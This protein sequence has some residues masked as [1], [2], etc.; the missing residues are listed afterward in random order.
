MRAN[1]HAYD[2]DHPLSQTKKIGKIHLL[3]FVTS[4]R[5]RI[6]QPEFEISTFVIIFVQ[7]MRLSVQCGLEAQNSTRSKITT[8]YLAGATYHILGGSNMVLRHAMRHVYGPLTLPN[9]P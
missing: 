5:T 9:E 7:L 2:A 6:K 4:P 3:K 1:V 8:T